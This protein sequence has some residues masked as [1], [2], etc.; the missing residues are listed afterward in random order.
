MQGLWG[1][2]RAIAGIVALMLVVAVPAGA[3]DIAPS[4]VLAEVRAL[5]AELASIGAPVPEGGADLRIEGAQP[6]EVWF[7]ALV[8][9]RLINDLSLREAGRSGSPPALV[10]ASSI[11]PADVRDVVLAARAALVPVLGAKGGAASSAP[12][13]VPAATQPTDVLNALLDTA[14]ALEH[15]G[16]QDLGSL[17]QESLTRSVLHAAHLLRPLGVDERIPDDVASPA[18]DGAS[19]QAGLLDLLAQLRVLA[20]QAGQRMLTVTVPDAPASPGRLAFQ[21]ATLVEAELA[22]LAAAEEAGQRVPTWRVRGADVAANSARLGAL[23]AQVDRL[24]GS[25]G[26]R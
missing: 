9:W 12:P 13:K 1:K 19:L 17:T 25:G 23:R 22:F 8:V 21:L 10:V 5:Q 26:E 2:G 24:V 20:G 16:A 4:H 7:Q 6:R 3:Q 15:L 14:A 11:R 18:P